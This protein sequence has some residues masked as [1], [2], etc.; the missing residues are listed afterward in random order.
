M[1]KVASIIFLSLV[2]ANMVTDIFG[3]IPPPAIETGAAR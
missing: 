2:A 1:T 3:Y